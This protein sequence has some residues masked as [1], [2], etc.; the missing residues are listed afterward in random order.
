[1][2]LKL[3]TNL[4]RTQLFGLRILVEKYFQAAEMRFKIVKRIRISMQI[5]QPI[6]KRFWI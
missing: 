1:M 6:E 2:L 5:L 4:K 3:L